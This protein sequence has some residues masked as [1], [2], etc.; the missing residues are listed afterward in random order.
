MT[1]LGPYAI[2]VY[3][4]YHKHWFG[5]PKNARESLKEG[6][7][8]NKDAIQYFLSQRLAKTAAVH[9]DDSLIAAA[10]NDIYRVI[11][12]VDFGGLKNVLGVIVLARCEPEGF[13]KYSDRASLTNIGKSQLR[14]GLFIEPNLNRMASCFLEASLAGGAAMGRLP[15]STC[16]VSGRPGPVVSA[17]CKAWP[18]A[19]PEWTCPV[20]HAGNKHLLVE[21]VALSEA[22]YRALTVGANL[23]QGLTKPLHRIVLPELFTPVENRDR[24]NA[25]R[26]RSKWPSEIFGSFFLLP[27]QDTLLADAINR[28]DFARRLLAMLDAPTPAEQLADRYLTAVTGFD[29][30]LPVEL[31][32][33]DFR[34]TLVYFSRGKTSEA[35]IQLRAYIQD[36]LPSTAG[37]LKKLVRPCRE[38]MAELVQLLSPKTSDKHRAYL[39]VCYHSVPYFLARGYG[40]SHLWTT[41]EQCLHRR[42]L[43]E[44]PI[45]AHVAAHI[46]SVV[47]HWPASRFEVIDEVIFLLVCCDFIRRYNRQ[48][49]EPS[50]EDVMPMRPW[51]VL[52]RAYEREPIEGMDFRSIA[53][54]GFACGLVLRCF[55]RWYYVT[56]EK[57]FLKHRVLT[58]GTDLGPKDIQRGVTNIRSVAAKFDDLRRMVEAGQLAYY[59]K[60][61]RKQHA[62][63]YQHRL[64]V[65]L[66]ALNSLSGEFD[67]GRDELVSGFWS[68]YCLQGYDRPRAPESTQTITNGGES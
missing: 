65:V 39:G 47:P 14:E 42:P 19:L 44:A 45:V 8:K 40:G 27:L 67:K 57:D 59:P 25:A 31:D 52:I 50:K 16:T 28:D 49:A 51:Q 6:W 35:D 36:V 58:F 13:Y 38:Q 17:Y 24:Q 66:N 21:G 18:W 23:F 9:L 11:S 30:F 1:A 53:E 54:L 12:T 4:I 29:V 22:M 26:S 15:Q 5:D 43:D 46:R 2:P 32:R 34:L 63:D 62:G 55:S 61:E 64:G 41:L 3:P 20:P 68:G 48:V 7:L 33:D 56:Q 10:S 37:R 60:E